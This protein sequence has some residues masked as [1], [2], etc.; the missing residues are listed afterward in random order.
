ML[1]IARSLHFPAPASSK[2]RE[3]D[4]LLVQSAA[5]TA[6]HKSCCTCCDCELAVLL[7]RKESGPGPPLPVLANAESLLNFR[8]CWG[9]YIHRATWIR[10][11]KSWVEN[12]AWGREGLLQGEALQSQSA[13]VTFTLFLLLSVSSAGR[14]PVLAQR[15]MQ[16]QKVNRCPVP[17]TESCSKVFQVLSRLHYQLGIVITIVRN[18]QMGKL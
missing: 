12:Y 5:V 6:Q 3:K 11:P 10:A 15:K 4:S 14:A 7:I 1:E 9:W 8:V 13:E 16:M 2:Q 17:G 18:V